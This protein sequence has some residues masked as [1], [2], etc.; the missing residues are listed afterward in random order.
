MRRNFPA[1]PLAF[2]LVFPSIGICAVGND[3]AIE[4]VSTK[5]AID[6]TRNVEYATLL[7][8]AITAG[9]IIWYSRDWHLLFGKDVQGREEDRLEGR[10]FSHQVHPQV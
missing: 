4:K 1:I 6:T 10:F 9:V 2:I 3:N 8:L 7:V 5:K